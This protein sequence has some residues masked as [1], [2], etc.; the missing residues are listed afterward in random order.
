MTALKSNAGLAG[1]SL[2]EGRGATL[3]LL[4]GALLSLGGLIL[5]NIEEADDWQAIFYRSS[6][7]SVGLLVVL[8]LRDGRSMPL[9]VLRA[10]WPGLCA[11]LGVALAMISYIM[12]VNATSVANALFLLAGA[13][14]L[15]ALLGLVL[16]R[17][18]VAPATWL[19][20]AGALVGIA[21][22]VWHGFA[23]GTVF[24]NVMGLLT[25]LGF[26]VFAVAL[27]WGREVDMLP[28]VLLGGVISAAAAGVMT[29]TG[30][31]FAVP[32]G[33]VALCLLFS[34]I[35]TSTLVMFTIGARGVPPAVLTLLS[36]T[37]I[38]L[39]PVWV[40]LFLAEVPDTATL[41]GGA[42][43]LAAIAGQAVSSLTRG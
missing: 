9:T 22:M 23:A 18:R 26:A 32:L 13:P 21:I 1:G 14:V 31:G 11:G 30:S 6:G 36:M 33:D 38:L 20:M 17:E 5:R 41:I 19:A 16:L 29:A 27:R 24:G 34:V 8:L 4:G 35:V 25:A 42:V 39:G 2:G 15:A 3:V 12:A 43:L 40:W 10:G 28:A 37:E 7:A